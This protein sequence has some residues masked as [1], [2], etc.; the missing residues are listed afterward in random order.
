LEVVLPFSGDVERDDGTGKYI[1]TKQIADA[2]V[3]RGYDV[4]GNTEEY[5]QKTLKRIL[6]LAAERETVAD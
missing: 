1:L 3:M 6:A 2:A 5:R 4:E